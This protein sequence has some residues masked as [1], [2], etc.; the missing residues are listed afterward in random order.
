MKKV[1]EDM[2]E[3]ERLADQAREHRFFDTT[4]KTDFNPKSYTENTVGRRVM[5]NQD[6]KT[7]SLNEKD[8]QLQVEM[9]TWRR[10]Q[11]A[12]DDDL[13]QRIPKG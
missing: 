5:R 10:T 11:K 6:G 8:E 2:K 12:T 4:N 3:K 9:G 1:A 7:V 13:W